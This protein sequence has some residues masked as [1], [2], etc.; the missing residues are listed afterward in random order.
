MKTFFIFIS[1]NYTIFLAKNTEKCD[2]IERKF[3][4]ESIKSIQSFDSS[5]LDYFQQP[6]VSMP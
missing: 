1:N 4:S 6:E 3:I 5:L 2:Y